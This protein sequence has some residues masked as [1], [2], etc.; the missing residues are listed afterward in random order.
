MVLVLQ[1]YKDFFLAFGMSVIAEK[2]IF[3]Y[4]TEVEDDLLLR[5]Q[6]A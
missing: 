2:S 4:R 1:D 6:I 5:D 3:L